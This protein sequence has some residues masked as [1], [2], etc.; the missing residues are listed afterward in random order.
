MSSDQSNRSSSQAEGNIATRRDR[1]VDLLAMFGDRYRIT[2]LLAVNVP[3]RYGAM[4]LDDWRQVAS[5]VAAALA[6]SRA[7]FKFALRSYQ[8]AS[9]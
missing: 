5:R 8:S 7:F 3:A 9:S 6:A 2:I 4:L 1:P